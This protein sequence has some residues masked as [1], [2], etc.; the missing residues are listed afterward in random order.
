VKI[1]DVE[2]IPLTAPLP[3][4][5][6]TAQDSKTSVSLVLV[7]VATDS[8][9]V[10]W[11]EVLGRWTP[12]SYA[13]IVDDL[14]APRLIG[15]DPFEA[16]AIWADM[17]S[18]LTG[19]GGGML[20]EAIAGVDIALWDVMGRSLGLP[21]HRLLG[22]VGRIRL[23]AYASS[24]MVDDLDAT[25]E[26]AE[27]LARSRFRAV[28]LKVGGDLREDLRRVALVRSILG[29]DIKLYV[30]ANWGYSLADAIEF[31]RRA[32]EFEIGWLE[33]P[34]PP[35]DREGYQILA[36]ASP[37]PIAAGESE[38]TAAGIRD[39]ITS[40]ALSYVQPDVARAGG[41][42]ETRKIALL[43][44]A[45][46]TYF[47]PHVGF[48]GAICLA[49][50]MQ[51]AAASANFHSLETMII[52]NPLREELALAP[53]GLESQLGDD[54]TMPVPDGPGLGIELD[55]SVVARYRI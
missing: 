32:T 30:D 10:G 7:R 53:I 26:A 43:A 20:V 55:M 46:D 41:I 19:R 47:A 33:E 31:G 3:R 37:T 17:N 5:M 2:A 28:K 52:P 9:V 54:G 50:T 21:I 51:L 44:Q 45:F 22:G 49:A 15:R 23:P 13:S 12:R 25:R 18:S 39:L 29:P 34:L 40:R 27:R 6:R 4:V 35:H 36:R 24:I 16:E 11:G 48:S 1:V 8:D 14:L 42:T 38:Y